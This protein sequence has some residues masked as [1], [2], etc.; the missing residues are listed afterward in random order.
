MNN[1]QIHFRAEFNIKEG[2]I[3]E[4]KRLIKEMSFMVKENEPETLNYQFYL[5]QDNSKCI[6]HETYLNSEAAF[7]H[8]NGRASQTILPRIFDVANI[9]KFDVYGSPNEELQNLLK[10]FNAQTYQL[11]TG[12][13]R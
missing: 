7:I 11:F 8:A 6:V 5:N 10:N 9:V 2:K 3:E 1:N 12:F 4:Y 13:S